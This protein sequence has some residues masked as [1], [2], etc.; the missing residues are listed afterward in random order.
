MPGRDM[1]LFTKI[2]YDFV[3]LSYVLFLPRIYKFVGVQTI[4]T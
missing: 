3:Y 2:C 1:N 4:I